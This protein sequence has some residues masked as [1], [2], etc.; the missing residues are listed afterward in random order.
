M[1]RIT[2]VLLALTNFALFAIALRL[3]FAPERRAPLAT[4]LM[5]AVGSVVTCLHVYGL[6]TSPLT[7][8]AVTAAAGLYVLAGGLFLWAA[9]SVRGRGFRLAYVPGTP[10][11]VFSGGP[12][13]WF[14]H[15]LYLSY[16]LAWIAGAVAVLSIH[17]LFTV[18]A[19]GAF[20]VG[21]AY[22]EERQMLRSSAGAEYRAYRRRTGVL[23]PKVLFLG[24][25]P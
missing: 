18:A 22:R 19:M 1:V 23:L 25:A 20:Y 2:I 14:R 21:A 11:P 17:L 24:R 6:A 13:R 7:V 8:R 3:L 5:V 12:Y 16:T 9:R 4:R 10:G 15:P